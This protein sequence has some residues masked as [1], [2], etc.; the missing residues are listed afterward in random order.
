MFQILVAEDD[1]NTRR[2]MEAIEQCLAKYQEGNIGHNYDDRYNVY[3][4]F[5]EEK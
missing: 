5:K 2:L 1:K 3:A 4:V